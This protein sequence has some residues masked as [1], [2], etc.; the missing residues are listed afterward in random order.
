MAD[1]I[2]SAVEK[3]E[4]WLGKPVV[5][6]SD[7]VAQTQLPCVIECGQHIRVV[8]LVVFKN[9]MDDDMQADSVHSVQS[10]YNSYAGSQAVLGASGTT[11]LNKIPGIP[12]FSGTEREKDTVSCHFRC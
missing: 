6:T 10:G 7:E 8:E 2:G 11:I 12:C 3:I 9:W 1:E 5:I 4:E